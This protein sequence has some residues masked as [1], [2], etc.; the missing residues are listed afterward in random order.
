MIIIR[1]CDE[2]NKDHKQKCRWYAHTYH[3]KNT[4]CVAK[5]WFNL[6][7]KH[8]MGLLAHEV[9]HLLVNRI[10]HPERMADIKANKFFGI[11]IKY[12]RSSKYCIHLQRLN[13]KD[14][15]IV[16]RWALDNVKIQ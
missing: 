12:D 16:Y 13:Y 14:S 3:Y 10:H 9:G 6:P 11:K 5:Q 2:V 1:E 4:I 8:Q 15:K 7:L